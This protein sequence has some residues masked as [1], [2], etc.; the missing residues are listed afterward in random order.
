[1]GSLPVIRAV[2]LLMCLAPVCSL[3]SEVNCEKPVIISMSKGFKPFSSQNAK[4]EIVGIDADFIR[5]T[6]DR[7]G[8]PYEFVTLPFGRALVELAEGTIDMVPY[9]S[10]SAD[11]KKFAKFSKPYRNKTVGLIFLTEEVE[12]VSLSSL[13][14]VIA[15]G[16][17]LGHIPTTFRGPKFETFIKQPGTSDHIF[18]IA[19][20]AEGLRMLDAG[21]IDAIVGGPASVLAIAESMGFENRVAEHQLV[22]WS[23]PVHFMYSR[24]SVPDT[25][26]SVI[27]T[28]ITEEV[29]EQAYS[30]HFGSMALDSEDTR[31]QMN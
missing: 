13:D 6:F 29:A 20:T 25:L 5:K 26:V 3:A 17:V 2:F 11:R 23:D 31:V 24:K 21:R 22:I 15:Q 30:E 14:D 12:K 1:M 19:D 18:N 8:C 28:A 9:S 7:A 16:L 27:N 4:G 10:K